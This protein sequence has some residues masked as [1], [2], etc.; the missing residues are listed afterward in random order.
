MA[1]MYEPDHPDPPALPEEES[2]TA[3]VGY[4]AWNVVEHSHER[5]GRVFPFTVQCVCGSA[6]RPRH[7]TMAFVCGLCGK[8][9]S[10]D[11]VQKVTGVHIEDY[12]GEPDTSI[13][14]GWLLASPTQGTKWTSPILRAD[15]EPCSYD[16]HDYRWTDRE[17]HCHGIY[18]HDSPEWSDFYSS[19]SVRAM[20]RVELTGKIVVHEKGYR[21]EAARIT[22]LVLNPCALDKEGV[23]GGLADRYACDVSFDP[24]H[25][26]QE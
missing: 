26:T 15:G 6:M 1:G 18:A 21:A 13:P 7:A 22:R 16:P 5:K 23:A 11:M 17:D 20:G 25:L 2:D 4:R 9:Y 10:A 14:E 12:F 24:T 8:S 3:I 19:G